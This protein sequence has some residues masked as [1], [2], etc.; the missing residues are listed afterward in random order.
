MRLCTAALQR[1]IKA[2]SVASHYERVSSFCRTLTP[3]KPGGRLFFLGSDANPRWAYPSLTRL[4]LTRDTDSLII[5]LPWH[6]LRDSKRG[7]RAPL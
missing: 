1:G 2:H 6:A 7:E 4:G 5:M 3:R